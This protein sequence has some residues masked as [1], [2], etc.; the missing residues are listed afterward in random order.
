MIASRVA[1]VPELVEDGV[2]GF[3]VPPGDVAAW[4]RGCGGCSPTPALARRMGAA[5]RAKVAAEFDIAREARRLAALFAGGLGARPARG[6]AATA[7]HR[8]RARAGAA[9]TRA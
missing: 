6:A 9:V 4:P 3:L 5:G 1:G 8:R 7:G 2:S